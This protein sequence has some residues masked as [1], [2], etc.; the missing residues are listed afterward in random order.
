MKS[1]FIVL[2][3][4]ALLAPNPI[5][6]WS[7]PS[8]RRD[9]E[10]WLDRQY[11]FS[12]DKVFKSIQPKKN[13][14]PGTIMASP[15]IIKPNP[16]Y[17][18]HWVRDASL[19]MDAL[20]G[21]LE[22]SESENDRNRYYDLFEKYN[23]LTI[24]L[25]NLK[26]PDALK[27]KPGFDVSQWYGE[28]KFQMDATPFVGD[29]GR[30]QNDG[31]ASRAFATARYTKYRLHRY[32][33]VTHL[34]NATTPRA[35]NKD[36]DFVANNWKNP[37]FEIWEEV[38][39]THFYTLMVQRR[40]MLDGAALAK[41]LK[42]AKGS[43]KYTRVA[44]QISAAIEKFWD[45][46]KGYVTVTH[47]RVGGLDYKKSGL[48]SQVILASLHA[49]KND[50]F[51]TPESDA[52]LATWLA[53]VKK[54]QGLYPDNVKHP[55]LAPAIGRYPED[56][57]NGFTA[58]ANGGNGWML[59]TTAMAECLYRVRN[60]WALEEHFTVT[61]RNSAFLE[62]VTNNQHKFQPGQRYNARSS[63]FKSVLHGLL[64]TADK[65][66]ERVRHHTEKDGLH[67][68]EQWNRNNGTQQ[69]AE[70]L[71]WSYTSFV[72]AFRARQRSLQS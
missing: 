22:R 32:I 9:L 34:Y 29:W 27:K 33:E 16:D 13:A 14:F 18:Y 28:P 72:T 68:S 64:K 55:K 25:Q 21:L 36:L 60:H 24:H 46:K 15:T 42:D 10:G 26:I 3:V 12:V 59:I 57:Y 6:S 30:P 17:Y 23:N 54:F 7:S 56:Q 2:S 35:L 51:Y 5:N 19:T 31:P 67:L 52:I 71:T 45:D 53:L 8:Q 1:V 58:F 69:G 49:S 4:L 61:K 62:Y 38:K 11:K 66:L 47:N 41:R 39:G 40:A 44:K 20:A 70:D 37:S 63:V 43:E 50:G 65:F 48:D